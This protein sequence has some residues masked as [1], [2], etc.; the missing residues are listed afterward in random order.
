MSTESTSQQKDNVTRREFLYYAWLSSLTAVAVGSGGAAVAFAYPR[1]KEG[2][3]GG[4]FVVGK[5]EEFEDGSVTTI[6]DGKFFLVRQGDEFKALYQ[7]CT[8]L[9]CLLRHSDEGFTCPC[10]GSQYTQDG[11]L[12]SS[13]ASRD[14]DEF[15]VEIIGGNIVVDTGNRVKGQGR[16][17]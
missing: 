15:D 10:H 9:G 17:T 1:F 11:T 8:H 6:R 4:K 12:I 7:V 14:M 5:V 13:P 2:E 16:T 3:F